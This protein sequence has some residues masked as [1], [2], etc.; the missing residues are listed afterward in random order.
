MTDQHTPV[1]HFAQ[2]DARHN[3]T[4]PSLAEKIAKL[5]EKHLTFRRAVV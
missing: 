2:V 1:G 4:R 3:D 5:R